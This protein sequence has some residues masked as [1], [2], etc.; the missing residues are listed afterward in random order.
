[1]EANTPAAS[2]STAP[3]A[4]ASGPAIGPLTT[5]PFILIQRPAEKEPAAQP[6][7]H[8]PPWT[9]N[10]LLWLAGLLTVIYIVVRVLTA[11][12]SRRA[13]QVRDRYHDPNRRV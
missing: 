3:G 12:S 2:P 10:K 11:K 7:P 13:R 1:M 6:Q 9:Q 8:R 4:P 5:G